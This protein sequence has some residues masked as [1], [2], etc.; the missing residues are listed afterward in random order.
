MYLRIGS[1]YA[2]TGSQPRHDLEPSAAASLQLFD[3]ANLR[4][5]LRRKPHVAIPAPIDSTKARRQNADYGRKNP[6]NTL[7]LDLLADDLRIAAIMALP[8]AIAEYDHQR[9]G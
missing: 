4:P 7:D 3:L 1:L 6:S 2:D 5:R 9:P 8:E